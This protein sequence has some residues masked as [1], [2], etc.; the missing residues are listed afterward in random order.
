MKKINL[1]QKNLNYVFHQLPICLKV[2]SD[3]LI[4]P[5]KNKGELNIF[6]AR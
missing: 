6:Y 3:I 5:D 1:N 4:K 2:F